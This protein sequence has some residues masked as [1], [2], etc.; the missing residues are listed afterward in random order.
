MSTRNVEENCWSHWDQYKYGCLYWDSGIVENQDWFS[1]DD[2]LGVF[3]E[4]DT[5]KMEINTKLHTIKYFKNDKELGIVFKNDPKFIN[6][7]EKYCMAILAANNISIQ[8]LHF[9]Q[10]TI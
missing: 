9:K 5:I 7:D 2:D 3:D 8:L 6:F 1:T 4:G 10:N